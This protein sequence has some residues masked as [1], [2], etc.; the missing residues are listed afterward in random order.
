[1]EI[2][3][4]LYDFPGYEGSSEGRIKNIRTQRILKAFP[5]LKGRMQVSL[6][7]DGKPRTVVVRRVIAKTFL[8]DHPGMDVRHK[9]RDPHNNSVNNL[10]WVSRSEL[11]QNA[12]DRGSKIPSRRTAVRV[13]ETGEIYDT[14][15]ECAKAT[16]CCRSEIFK[17]MAGFRPHVKGLH[18]ERV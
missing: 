12:F 5:G 14:V 11:I 16:G 9:D 6:V 8:D 17:Q 10:E 4:P 13:V 7:R 3:K 2:W 15:N 18:F 1:M